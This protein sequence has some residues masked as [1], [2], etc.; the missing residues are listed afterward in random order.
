MPPGSSG[1]SSPSPKKTP[2]RI[3]D[4]TPLD[5]AMEALL[6]AMEVVERAKAGE[7][8]TT[9]VGLAQGRETAPFAHGRGVR[10]GSVWSPDLGAFYVEDIIFVLRRTADGARMGDEQVVCM[11]YADD[12]ILLEDDPVVMQMLLARAIC[13]CFAFRIVVIFSRLYNLR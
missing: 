3:P 4:N 13:D 10:Q 6:E 12:L 1:T 8:A 5:P 2:P 9:K 7:G 11:F